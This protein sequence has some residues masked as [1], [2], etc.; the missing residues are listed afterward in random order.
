MKNCKL[1]ILTGDMIF[2]CTSWKILYWQN[3]KENK[4]LECLSDLNTHESLKQT[5]NNQLDVFLTINPN[6]I[7]N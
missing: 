3:E 6:I 4:N 2:Q 7:I 1:V 5:E